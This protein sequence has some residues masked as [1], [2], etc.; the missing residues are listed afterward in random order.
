MINAR[1]VAE[2]TP[3]PHEVINGITVTLRQFRRQLRAGLLT[4]SETAYRA[5]EY[6]KLL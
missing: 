6:L 4:D 5:L 1:P 3:D 2:P